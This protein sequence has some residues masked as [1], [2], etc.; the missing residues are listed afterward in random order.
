[1]ERAERAVAQVHYQARLDGTASAWP[2]LVAQKRAAYEHFRESICELYRCYAE[3][4]R[5]HRAQEA[6]LEQADVASALSFPD[7]ATAGHRLAGCLV[8]ATGW[9]VVLGT[10]PPHIPLVEAMMDPDPGT[11]E[12]P[13]RAVERLQRARRP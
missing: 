5:V 10:N 7:V 8:P 2:A 6:A 1:L 12:F 4:L 9:S 11:R 3:V 13:A